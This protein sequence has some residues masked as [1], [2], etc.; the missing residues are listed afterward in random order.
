MQPDWTG[1]AKQATGAKANTIGCEKWPVSLFLA[2][3]AP[4][5]AACNEVVNP[6]NTVGPT[7]GHAG[8]RHTRITIGQQF[9]ADTLE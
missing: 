1:P 3:P 5:I 7:N 2:R 6:Q 8:G 4:S 9:G